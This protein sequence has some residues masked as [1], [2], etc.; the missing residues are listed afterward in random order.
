MTTLAVDLGER[1]IGIAIS[2]SLGVAARPLTRVEHVSLAGDA[3]RVAELAARYSA[4][5]IVVG[6]PLNLDGSAGPAARRAR[7]FASAL[8][9]QTAA[10]VVCWSETLTTVEAQERVRG[11]GKTAQRQ[12]QENLDRVAAAVILQ[13]YLDAQRRGG[14]R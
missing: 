8:R 4:A 3:A 10:E 13:D 11:L 1:R 9:K 14:P 5:R 2:D 6:L 12:H 7:R